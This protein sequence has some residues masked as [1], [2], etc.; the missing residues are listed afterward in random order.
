VPDLA[1]LNGEILKIEDAMVPIE[2]R[3]YQFG[4]AVYEFIE[5]FDSHILCLDEH[6]DRLENSM[7]ALDFPDFPAKDLKPVVIDL[8][9][10]SRYQRA[11]CYIQI[12]RGIQFRTHSYTNESTPQVSMT[13]RDLSGIGTEVNDIGI[14]VRTC[15]DYRWGMC[16][17][18]TVQLLP[19]ALEQHKAQ[20]QGLNDTVFVSPEG[21]VREGTCTNIFMVKD[22]SLLTHPLNHHI[23]AGITRHLIIHSICKNNRIP[24]TEDYFLLEDLYTADEA[25][26]CSTVLKIQPIIEV[27]GKII[28]NGR[29]GPVTRSIQNAYDKLVYRKS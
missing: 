5:S 17:V 14:K 16:H 15:N 28:G 4:D 9:E 1:Y 26:L 25:F 10:K 6:L 23:L 20:K 7:K 18:K 21:V 11:G 12:S 29:P 27:D 2:D 8:F 24:V 13:I 22:G 3:G 19:A